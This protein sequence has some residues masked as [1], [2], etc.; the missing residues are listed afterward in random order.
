MVDIK[1]EWDKDSHPLL[2]QRLDDTLYTP[3]GGR[4]MGFE[5][6]LGAPSTLSLL[7]EN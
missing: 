1:H 7:R 3:S 2:L 5:H 6:S 4:I